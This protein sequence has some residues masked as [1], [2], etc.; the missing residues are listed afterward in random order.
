MQ[1][2]NT[3]VKGWVVYEVGEGSMAENKFFMD[4]NNAMAYCD[5]A[6]QGVTRLIQPQYMRCDNAEDLHQ[7]RLR[8]KSREYER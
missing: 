6:K 2:S 7:S 4:L 1:K 8:K 5:H 3:L